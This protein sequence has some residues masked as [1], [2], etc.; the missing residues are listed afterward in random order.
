MSSAPRILPGRPFPLTCGSG[1]SFAATPKHALIVIDMP[2]LSCR[3]LRQPYGSS[4]RSADASLC[5]RRSR[6]SLHS[7]EARS[8]APAPF[9]AGKAG[10]VTS[11]Q[12][13]MIKNHIK[14]VEHNLTESQP[15]QH[16][17]I[18]WNQQHN[19]LLRMPNITAS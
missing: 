6:G 2:S 16:R 10:A 19:A 1:L 14:E 4:L 7:L 18:K 3:T 8:V 13:G 15:S 12:T 11:G 9:A 17:R 5:H